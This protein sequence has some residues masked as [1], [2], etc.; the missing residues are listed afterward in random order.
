M[1]L[2][3]LLGDSELGW[4]TCQR[5]VIMYYSQLVPRVVAAVL[6][7]ITKI[8]TAARRINW[9]EGPCY[10]AQLGSTIPPQPAVPSHQLEVQAE[11]FLDSPGHVK[12]TRT[13][14]PSA[15]NAKHMDVCR[16]LVSAD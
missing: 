8:K 6:K 16:A 14:C 9:S 3:E 2:Q 1:T 12:V 4:P 7:A 15:L 5:E 13:H 10:L 11:D